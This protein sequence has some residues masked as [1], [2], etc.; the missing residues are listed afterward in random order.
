MAIA[1]DF[2]TGFDQLSLDFPLSLP[3]SRDG[4]GDLLSPIGALSKPL[5]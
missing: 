1:S 2:A 4:L 3:L 5:R